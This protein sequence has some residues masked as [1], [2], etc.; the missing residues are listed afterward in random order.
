MF[1]CK[2]CGS[3]YD[4]K[5][6]FCDCGNDVFEEV[7]GTVKKSTPVAVPRKIYKQ[8][9]KKTYRKKTFE[10]QYPELERLRNSFD[11]ISTVIFLLLV[12][13][14]LGIL[15][16]VGNPDETEKNNPDKKTLQ[17]PVQNLNIPSIDTF[18]DNSTAGII[19][20]EKS[21]AQKAAKERTQGLSDGDA[22]T[23]KQENVQPKNLM[24]AKIENT[25]NSPNTPEPVQQNSVPVQT[26]KKQIT[27]SQKALTPQPQKVSAQSQKTVTTQPK[28]PAKTTTTSQ[29]G[30]KKDVVSG[31]AQMFGVGSN[32]AAPSI[33]QKTQAIANQS[34]STANKSTASPTQ[35]KTT[36]TTS[37]TKQTP[38]TTAT[39]PVQQTSS[40]SQAT[41]RPKATIDTQA[42]QRELSNYKVGLRN[43]IGR[44]IDFANVV[45]DGECAVSFKVA[46]N[47]KLTSRTFSKQSSNVTLNDAVYSAVMA[48]P[49]YNPPP[50]GY[51]NETMTLRIRFYNGNFDI[52]LN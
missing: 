42:L 12:I 11:P 43:T 34:K 5:P 16:F 21:A 22:Q 10:E 9:E 45:G 52:S 17:E 29:T 48:T 41:L 4:I 18:W 6:D 36:T 1:K 44:K 15:F 13:L 26:A 31:L 24:L 35:Q 50:S 19:N 30:K 28:T 20:N 25:L 37:Q 8:E 40:Q 32:N 47:G 38:Q 46:S 7:A 39:K 33:P 51:K 14:G 2:E 23:V 3:E 27:Q 49:S